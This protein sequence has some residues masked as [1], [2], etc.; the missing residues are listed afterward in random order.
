MLDFE[1]KVELQSELQLELQLELNS[2]EWEL[3]L[4]TTRVC[5]QS[6]VELRSQSRVVK[7]NGRLACIAVAG[8]IGV[9]SRHSHAGLSLCSAPRV[10]IGVP[11]F[12]RRPLSSHGRQLAVSR[13]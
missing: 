5:T 8:P 1:H 11:Q 4:E 10:W 7:S 2:I 13:V 9:A 3:N 6:E 12:R